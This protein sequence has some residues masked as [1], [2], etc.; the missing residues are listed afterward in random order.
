MGSP[1]PDDPV[2]RA[3]GFEPSAH[4]L[5]SRCSTGL[6]YALA[7]TAGSIAPQARYSS[8]KRSVVD[9]RNRLDYEGASVG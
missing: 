7:S 3:E 9:K 4:G 6:S 2:V 8:T 5:K 1:A